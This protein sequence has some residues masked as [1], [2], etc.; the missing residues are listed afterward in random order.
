MDRSEGHKGDTNDCFHFES[1]FSSKK[2]LES[3]MGVVADIIGV[4]KT[5]TK[6]LCKETI[7]KITKDYTGGYYLVLRRNPMAPRVRPLIDIDYKYNMRKCLSF[8]VTEDS[9]RTK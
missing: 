4:V 8:I 2:S 3:A 1:W 5:N 6:G 7:E 9:G